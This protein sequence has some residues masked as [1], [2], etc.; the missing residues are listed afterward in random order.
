MRRTTVTDSG[1]TGIVGGLSEV[2]LGFT[3]SLKWAEAHCDRYPHT[4]SPVPMY[5]KFDR[6]LFATER[7]TAVVLCIADAD[8]LYM[9]DSSFLNVQQMYNTM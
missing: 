4:Y 8:I 3:L 9:Y 6:S 7:L 5:Y 1:D 2:Y